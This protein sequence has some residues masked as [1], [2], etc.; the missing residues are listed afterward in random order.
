MNTKQ[1]LLVI[2]VAGAIVFGLFRS[3]KTDVINE[4][5]VNPV[6]NGEP[7]NLCYSY[8]SKTSSGLTDRALLKMS[9]S[10]TNGSSV[11]GEFQNLPA[12]KDSKVGTFSGTAT[13]LDQNTMSRTANVL[14]DAKAE[15]TTV[16]EE[17]IIKFGD[18][19]AATAFGEMVK[20][21]NGVYVYKD[22]SKLTYGPTMNQVDCGLIDEMIVVESY[23]KTNAK[24]IIT[25]KAAVGGTWFIT[26][27]NIN[28]A[29]DTAEITYEDGH[30]AG[31][32]E[33]K[34]SFVNNK[35]TILGFTK[36]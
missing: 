34:Y 7:R 20:G 18:G 3:P 23:I 30:I 25:E 31:K 12:E 17:L 33:V 11:S 24:T 8:S 19:A 14:W 10:G 16:K 15:G 13:T 5:V 29:T 21:A 6:V 28:A 35:V 22:K 26:S 1:I 2:L 4:P 9:F 32:G 36:K 27:I